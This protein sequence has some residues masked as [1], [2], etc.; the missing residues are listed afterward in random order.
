MLHQSLVF[1]FSKVPQI[2]EQEA[3]GSKVQEQFVQ[4]SGINQ[5]RIK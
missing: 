3:R 2:E 5:C 1:I 4:D